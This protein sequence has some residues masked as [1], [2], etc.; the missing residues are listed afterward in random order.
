MN[1][2]IV[3]THANAEM[4]GGALRRVIELAR[5]AGVEVELPADEVGKHGIEPQVFANDRRTEERRTHPAG[6][7]PLRV[8]GKQEVLGRRAKALD[9]H[10]RFRP[11]ARRVRVHGRLVDRD[12]G[13][14]HHELD[15]HNRPAA[16]TWQGKPDVY[17]AYQALLLA[18]RPLAP[19]LS[20][21]LA[22]R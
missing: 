3:F 7:E 20:V 12:L 9:R 19:V 21:Q 4:T 2:A 13:S 1:R 10:Q 16:T 22:G 15:E 11:L 8:Q 5:A 18:S 14:W 6:I 17:H